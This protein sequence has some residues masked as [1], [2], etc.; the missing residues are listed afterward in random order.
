MAS[1]LGAF[2]VVR[3]RVTAPSH[4]LAPSLCPHRGPGRGVP[5]VANGIVPQD[6]C[7]LVRSCG[8]ARA[9]EHP[10]DLG[11]PQ[12]HHVPEEVQTLRE[13]WGCRA[14]IVAEKSRLQ[15]AGRRQVAA[16]FKEKHR[17]ESGR[18]VLVVINTSADLLG[19]S[20]NSN[21]VEC[22]LFCVQ[23]PHLSQK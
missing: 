14:P 5:W 9:T 4:I 12:E 6:V 13:A 1:C 18:S 21:T 17:L 10:R 11:A 22:R 23:E 19:R 16:L 3:R 20:F 8:S 2:S 15:P 7:L